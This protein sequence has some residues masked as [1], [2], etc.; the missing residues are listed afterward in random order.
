MTR[1]LPPAETARVLVE[2]LPYIP[3]FAGKS[4][5]VNLG[6]AAIDRKSDHALDQ[7]VLPL[8]SL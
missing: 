4:I 7:D 8:R 3:Q 5:V 6:G 1:D 2:A